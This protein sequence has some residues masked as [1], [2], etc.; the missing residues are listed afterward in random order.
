MSVKRKNKSMAGFVVWRRGGGGGAAVAASCVRS[1][2]SAYS[3]VPSVAR[4][5]H[6]TVA[7]SAAAAAAERSAS[8]ISQQEMVIDRYVCVCVFLELLEAF[9]PPPNMHPKP[10][11]LGEE[12]SHLDCC[13]S[14]SRRLQ[15][16]FLGS[17]A[18]SLSSSLSQSSFA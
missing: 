8:S 6:V 1:G 18:C 5:L 12:F 4:H 10:S 3:Q 9:V 14:S 13:C 2:V 17:L 16:I 7:A 11:L 15:R